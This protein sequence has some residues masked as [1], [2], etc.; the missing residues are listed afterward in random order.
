MTVARALLGKCL[1]HD[2]G[3]NRRVGRIVEVEA[4]LG[5]HDRA[6]HSS[7][8]LTPRTRVRVGPAGFAYVYRIYG[9]HHCVNVV[10]DSEGVGAAVLIRALEPLAGISLRCSGPG[11]LCSAMGIDRKRCLNPR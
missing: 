8:G 6:S 5:S 7:K 11:L 10:T 9:I 1:V 2:T 4:Y 3:F